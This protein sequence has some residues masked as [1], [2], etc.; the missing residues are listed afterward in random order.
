MRIKQIGHIILVMLLLTSTVGVTINKHFS[1][2]DHFSSALFVEAEAC[3]EIPCPCCDDS[4]EL[5][6]VEA[7]YI[8]SEFQLHDAIQLDLLFSDRIA[9]LQSTQLLNTTNLFTIEDAPPPPLPGL[10][11]LNQVFRL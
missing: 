7:D 4:S 11:I 2:G 10:C 5:I 6:K 3:C 8:A 9:L 1:G